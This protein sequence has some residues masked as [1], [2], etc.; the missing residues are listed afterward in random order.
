ELALIGDDPLPRNEEEFNAQ[1]ARA[2]TRLGTVTQ[3]MTGLIHAMAQSCQEL[4]KRLSILDKSAASLKKDLEEQLHHLI[5]PGFLSITRWQ[6]LQHLPRYLKGMLLRLDKYSKNPGRDQEQTEMIS[7]LWS[8]YIQRLN[9][10]RQAGTT[11]SNLELFRW[12]IEELRIS[13]FS[14]ELKTPMPVSVKRLQK[15]WESVRE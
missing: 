13:L 4:K 9:K 5:Y 6:Y 2:R 14:Q 8:Q 12:Q 1:V 7:T 10:H 3:E 15:L 11:D